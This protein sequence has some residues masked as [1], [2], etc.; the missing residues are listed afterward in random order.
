LLPMNM[1]SATSRSEAQSPGNERDPKMLRRCGEAGNLLAR[2]RDLTCIRRIQTAHDLGEV[3]FPAPFSPTRPC[4]S[5]ATRSSPRWPGPGPP[6]LLQNAAYAENRLLFRHVRP[7]ICRLMLP[8][9]AGHVGNHPS[10]STAAWR[11]AKSLRQ[12]RLLE[13]LDHRRR[14]AFGSCRPRHPEWLMPGRATR[15]APGAET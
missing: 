12:C 5:P 15:I 4:T 10:A 1:F 3:D 13:M 2:Q 8:F 7:S 9:T 14:A 6:K 11:T